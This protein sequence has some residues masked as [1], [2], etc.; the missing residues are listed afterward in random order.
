MYTA[1]AQSHLLQGKDIFLLMK[2]IFIAALVIVVVAIPT[3]IIGSYAKTKPAALNSPRYKSG[4]GGMLWVFIV[5]QIAW[6]LRAV[7]ETTF[8]SSEFFFMLARNEEMMLQ[9][10]VAV[11]PTVLALFLGVCVIYQIA[12]KRTPNA[13]G[14]A[15]VM[16]WVMGPGVAMFQSWFFKLALTQASLLQ[17]FGWAIF[18]SNYFAAS[19]R[20]ALTYGTPRGR[21]LAAQA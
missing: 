17:L 13:L 8:I 20:A 11:L 21:R 4:F 9:A 16:L 5:G 15:I 6:F 19:P 2:S 1:V 3:W 7:W 10:A 14:S 18:W 12:A